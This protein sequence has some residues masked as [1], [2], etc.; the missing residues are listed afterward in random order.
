[1]GSLLSPIVAD[2]ALQNL[3]LHTLDKLSFIH[4]FIL[5]TLM[6]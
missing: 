5:N 3:E 6:T 2:L 1:M 4:H